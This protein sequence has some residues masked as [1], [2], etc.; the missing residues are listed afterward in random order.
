MVALEPATQENGCL[1][2]LAGT[3]AMGRIDHSL[4]GQQQSAEEDRVSAAMERHALVH[5]EMDAGDVSAAMGDRPA[6]RI[7]FSS[8]SLPVPSGDLLPCAYPAVSAATLLRKLVSSFPA[9]P[10]QRICCNSASAPNT[11]ARSRWAL[12]CCYNTKANDPISES[13]HPNYRALEVLPDASLIKV[14]AVAEWSEHSDLLGADV[15]ESQA[16]WAEEA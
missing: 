12:T 1:K 9:S 8:N 6:R 4:L 14:G 16:A 3:Q 7:M 5:A 10:I 15:N 2:L 13:F 11:S